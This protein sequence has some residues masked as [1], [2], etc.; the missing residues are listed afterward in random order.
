MILPKNE[1]GKQ[2]SRCWQEGFGIGSRIPKALAVGNPFC[3][4]LT[5]GQKIKCGETL[6]ATEVK[7][8]TLEI[9]QFLTVG[10]GSG[11]LVT[12][13]KLYLDARSAARQRE[14]GYLQDQL[15]LLYSPLHLLATLNKEH[16]KITEKLQDALNPKAT[17]KPQ[18]EDVPAASGAESDQIIKLSNEYATK[19]KENN[20]KMRQILEANWSLIDVDDVDLLLAFVVDCV[21]M[22]VE[23]DEKHSQGVAIRVNQRL[24]TIFYVRPGFTERITA[25]WNAKRQRLSKLLMRRTTGGTP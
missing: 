3:A 6:P 7:M 20:A 5:P 9:F 18:P 19:F 16:L 24:G 12:A 1:H 21:R 11:F 10:L 17:A 15:R 13:I 22:Q 23:V 4:R 2:T 14:I 8:G 25:Q